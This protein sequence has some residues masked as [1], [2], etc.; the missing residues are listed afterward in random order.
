MAEKHVFSTEVGG[1]TLTV[2]IGQLAKQ[3]DGAVLV[4]YENTVVLSTVVA[5][6]DPKDLD[7]FPLMVVYDERQY[8]AGKIPGGFIK[9]EGRPSENAILAGRLI[10]RPIRPLFAEGF[11]NDVQIVNTVMSADIDNSPEMAAM[12]GSSLALTVS[13]IPFE[14]PIA[15]VKVGMIDDKFIV[16]PTREQMEA[17]QIDLTVAGTMEAINM[18]EAGANQVPE[19]VMLE[20]IMFGHAEIQKLIAFQNTIREQ[21]GNPK[22]EVVLYEIPEAIQTVVTTLVGEELVAAASIPKKQERYAAIDALQAI[23]LVHYQALEADAKT[24]KQAKEFANEI[25]KNE[26]RRLITEDKVRPDGRKIDE[27]RSLAA[28]TDLLPLTHGTALFT[29]GETQTL[30]VVTLGAAGEHQILDGLDGESTKRFMHHYNFPPFSVGETGRMGAPGRREIG[31]GALGERALSYVLPDE[32]TFPYTIR[33]VSEVLE[34]NGSTSQ[35]SIC[36]S[37]MALMAA[38]VPIVAPVAGIAMGLIS[39]GTNYSVLTDI[40]GLEDHLGDMD[41]KVAGTANGV[42]ALQMDIKIKG[43]T[44]EIL[45]EALAQAY[46]GRMHILETLIATIPQP[47]EDVAATA[48]KVHAMQIKV[49]Q[50]RT[51]IGTGGK[52][53]NQI[54][55]ETGVKIDIEEDGSVF[56]YSDN[57]EMINRAKQ[58]IEDLTREVELNSIYDAKV[59]RVE[60][61]GAF[62]E[63][64]PGKDALVH[65]S[66]LAHERVEKTE[67]VVKLGEIIKV[68][69]TEIDQ[70]GRVNASLKVLLPKPEVKQEVETT[71]KP[72]E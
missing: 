35:A 51:V 49:A 69:V 37:T 65:I 61:F 26:V 44:R 45:A 18:V 19:A 52:Q 55:D 46:K 17:S 67:D 6:K 70:Q 48:P 21:I 9:R 14:G 8:A 68:K 66:Q 72:M 20:A 56:I 43:I 53:I 31:H 64:F 12:F 58:I 22:R 36:S 40:Q 34:S 13:D 16:N 33:V 10:D 2:E 30:S 25:V 71:S 54:I 27:V 38:G 3:A 57:R 50:I 7:F 47:R 63:L 59:V 28:E 24:I 15:G 4:R 29:R 41:F 60:K 5:S 23:V 42:T 11:R 1:R 39:D 32:K 62:V